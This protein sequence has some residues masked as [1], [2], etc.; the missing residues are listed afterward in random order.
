MNNV[1]TVLNTLLKTAFAWDVIERLPCAVRLLPTPPTSMGFHDFDDYERLVEAA[2]ATD[3]RAHLT[4]L[5]G[6]E[7]GLRCGDMMALEWPISI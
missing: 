1:L 2:K 4:L 3:R 7:A 6:G 5:L